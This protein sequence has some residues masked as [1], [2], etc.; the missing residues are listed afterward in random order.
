MAKPAIAYGLSQRFAGYE[1]VEIT[2]L[3]RAY[4]YGR[5]FHSGTNTSGCVR[6]LRGVYK[7]RAVAERAAIEISAIYSDYRP[8]IIEIDKALR[9]MERERDAA[10]KTLIDKLQE[11]A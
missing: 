6:D 8:K 11:E 9:A 3:E 5:S 1:V 7:T 2:K 4:W 10:L